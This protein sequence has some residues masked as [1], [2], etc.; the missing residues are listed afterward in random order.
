MRQRIVLSLF[1]ALFV[2]FTGRPASATVLL[3]VTFD[4]L[5]TGSQAIVH[6]RIVSMQTEVTPDRLGVSTLV[7]LDVADQLKGNFGSRVTF[8][9]P[10]GRV[11]RY[12]RIVV[13]APVLA[14]G[15]EVVVFLSA[16][17]PSVP[18]LFG[19][20]QGVY[21]VSRQ[22]DA[23]GMVS[24]PIVAGHGAGAERIVRGDP[25]RQP[26]P[27]PEFTGRIRAIL[28]RTR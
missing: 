2:S 7:T 3:P 9:V 22:A 25:A 27:V 11:G 5:V 6:G 12:Q 13:G 16:R 20:S 21:R 26:L 24:Q 18:Y 19:L 15:D 23:R 10:G 28:E 4:E 14:E 1:W 8:R 17:G